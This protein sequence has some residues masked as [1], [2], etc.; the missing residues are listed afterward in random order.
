[1]KK[2]LLF[3]ILMI[4]FHSSESVYSQYQV[5]VKWGA[6]YTGI[7]NWVDQTREVAVDALLNVYVTG[8]RFQNG[9]DNDIVTIKY[10]SFGVQQWVV[11]YAGL[12]DDDGNALAVDNAGNVYV[13]GTSFATATGK[14]MVTIKYNSSG[15]VVWERRLLLNLEDHG[16]DIALDGSGNVYITGTSTSAGGGADYFTVK[17]NAAG[18]PL[19]V[20]RY[21][22]NYDD[23]AYSILVDASGNVYVTG[24]STNTNSDYCTIKYNSSGVQQWVSRYNG[25]ANSIDIAHEFGMDGSGNI[26]VTGESVN[27]SG[28]R[29]IVTVKY[30]NSGVQQWVNVSG[31]A[32]DDRG[33]DIAEDVSGN[34]YVTGSIYNGFNSDIVTLKISPTGSQLWNRVENG[35]GNGSDFGR[36]IVLDNFGNVYVAG[37]LSNPTNNFDFALVRYST[38]G[39]AALSIH[40]YN[41]PANGNDQAVSCVADQNGY[42]YSTGLSIGSGT[43]HD[44]LTLKYQPQPIAPILVSPANN[45]TGNTLIPLLNWNDVLNAESYTVQVSTNSGF[46]SFVIN[47]PGLT[48]S[49]YQVTA[50]A[51]QNNVNYYWRVC[52]VNATIGP[53][54]EV[55]NFRT[56]L[57]GI[58]PISTEIPEVYALYSNT[59]N[60]FNPGTD[61]RFDIPKSGFVTLKIF[62]ISGKELETLVK[63]KLDPGKYKAVF[64]GSNLSS[65][66][67][68]YQLSTVDFTKTM[69]MILLK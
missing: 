14:D 22:N 38:N 63:E 9:P 68:L 69:K 11:E 27:S 43:G 58:Q 59:P 5:G 39:G 19:W 12:E 29:D 15:S 24:T 60:P 40:T 31:F 13:V 16:A 66:V 28:Q 55:W 20:A 8:S 35:T 32:L 50:G 6:R 36:S 18:S 62:D 7:G 57:V 34:S 46:S 42:V 26:Y 49:Q 23:N 2:N 41:A 37:S 64:N 67:Y 33:Y 25:S 47:Q 61:I 65:G 44:Y 1:M 45:S 52:A 17:F 48:V 3:L 54:S 4:Y 51:L 53:W 30:N 21:D 56:A 10:N